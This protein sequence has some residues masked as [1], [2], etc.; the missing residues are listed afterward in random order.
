MNS[1]LRHCQRLQ[2]LPFNLR[3]ACS[4]QYSIALQPQNL[5]PSPVRT[6][7]CQAH[8]NSWIALRKAS[9]MASE[10]EFA[11]GIDAE[12]LR[13]LLNELQGQGW[14]LDEDKIGIK[15]TFYFRS[16]FKAVVGSSFEISSFPGKG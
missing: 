2:K 7:Y 16:Y 11:E 13:P 15:K 4:R 6:V 8:P 12:Q 5:R 1:A 3:P 9:T 14:G 10:P